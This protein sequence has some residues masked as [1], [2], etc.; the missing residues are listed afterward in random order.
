MVLYEVDIPTILNDIQKQVRGPINGYE[1]ITKRYSAP[2]PTMPGAGERYI[3]QLD[4]ALPYAT[5]STV[6]PQSVN[7]VWVGKWSFLATLENAVVPLGRDFFFRFL[8]ALP[9]GNYYL[10]EFFL[11][12]T[13][14]LSSPNSQITSQGVIHN[15]G[16]SNVVTQFDLP[17]FIPITHVGV[18]LAGGAFTPPVDGA[19]RF[20]IAF[21]GLRIATNFPS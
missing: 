9:D 6:G 3:A 2:F 20:E 16:G 21:R 8:S 13:G 14:E 10:H 4:I 11:G 19:W 15:Y 1:Y 12:N 17:D 5:F 18:R 7:S